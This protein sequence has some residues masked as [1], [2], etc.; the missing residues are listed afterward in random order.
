MV[1]RNTSTTQNFLARVG[2]AA[3]ANFSPISPIVAAPVIESETESHAAIDEA[4]EAWKKEM[5]LDQ[6]L[7]SQQI[8]NIIRYELAVL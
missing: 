6:P 7:T 5:G 8:E 2:L 4:Y 3:P 1:T